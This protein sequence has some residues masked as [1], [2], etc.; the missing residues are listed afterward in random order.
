MVAIGIWSFLIWKQIHAKAA[1]E[2]S[3]V[4]KCPFFGWNK[5]KRP[6]A[7]VVQDQKVGEGGKENPS[8]RDYFVTQ[9]LMN[10]KYWSSKNFGT[11]INHFSFMSFG[12]VNHVRL[13]R[14]V[15]LLSVTISQKVGGKLHLHATVFALLYSWHTH[16]PLQLIWK[17]PELKSVA[18]FYPSV[19]FD[20]SIHNRFIVS[21]HGSKDTLIYQY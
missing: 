11:H 7:D 17:A 1:W 14:L 13:C 16:A 12:S 5:V 2:L 9:K 8:H 10:Y 4:M 18:S 3:C 19:A 6:A 21:Q 20:V 15:D